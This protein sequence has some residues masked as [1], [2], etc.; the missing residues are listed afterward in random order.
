MKVKDLKKIVATMNEEALV[1]NEQNEEILHLYASDY[2]IISN[3]LPIGT[4]NRTGG[5]VYPSVIDG[6]SAFSPEL[7]EDLYDMEWTIKEPS[8]RL[9]LQEH[10]Y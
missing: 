9:T 8:W 5:N 2:L 6:Y 3:K 7:D 1:L 4:C 10:L